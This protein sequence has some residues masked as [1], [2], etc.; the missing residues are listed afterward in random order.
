MIWI[1]ITIN[2]AG[3]LWYDYE[4]EITSFVY[5]I[6]IYT[7]LDPNINKVSRSDKI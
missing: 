7:I 4:D 3:G 2:E 1:I 6:F 5:N